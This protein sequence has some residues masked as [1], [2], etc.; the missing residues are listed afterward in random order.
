MEEIALQILLFCQIGIGTVDNILLFLHNFSPILTDSQLMPIHII[1]TNWALANA[2]NLLLLSFPYY[3]TLF[4][5]RKPPTNIRRKLGYFFHGVSGGTNM[6]SICALSTYQFLILFPTNWA[7][8][9]FREI[10]PK[11]VG[12]LGTF[13]G[14]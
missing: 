8:V 5:P 9:M 6:C 13:A 10:S 7:K 4:V 3:I 11:I 14:C 12:I 2:F 1:L